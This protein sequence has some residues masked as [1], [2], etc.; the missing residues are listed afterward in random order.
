MLHSGLLSIEGEESESDFPSNEPIQK[1]ID[2]GLSDVE[3]DSSALDSGSSTDEDSALINFK[4]ST[5]QRI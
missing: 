5:C 1:S 3:Y 4:L 2:H